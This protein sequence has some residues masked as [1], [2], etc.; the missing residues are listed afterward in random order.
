MPPTC[1]ESRWSLPWGQCSPRKLALR[2]SASQLMPVSLGLCSCRVQ[3]N[4]TRGED[5]PF[6]FCLVWPLERALDLQES[7]GQTVAFCL[8][9]G[10]RASQGL[11]EITL[12]P[13]FQAPSGRKW[14]PLLGC[15]CGGS[16]S[17]VPVLLSLPRNGRQP[18][19]PCWVLELG[20]SCSLGMMIEREPRGPHGV[21]G[22]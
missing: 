9:T 18:V 15:S 19:P 17:S 21:Q 14:E 3:A 4:G 1:R 22:P 20:R 8:K 2:T 13:P 7:E 16:A 5:N 12:C 10:S 11:V 6:V